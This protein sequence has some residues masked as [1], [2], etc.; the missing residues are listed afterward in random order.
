[1]Y[2]RWN[3]INAPKVRNNWYT[4]RLFIFFNIVII[5]LA[6]LYCSLYRYHSHFHLWYHFFFSFYNY[7][8][9]NYPDS[10]KLSIAFHYRFLEPKG[11]KLWG[12]NYFCRNSM[13]SKREKFHFA[14]SIFEKRTNELIQV[15][16]ITF[17][18]D[19]Y[20]FRQ[21]YILYIP[22]MY[23]KTKAKDIFQFT[24]FL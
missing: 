2:N 21:S 5:K 23:F 8:S 1:M 20:Y 19:Q 9:S 13:K 7:H 3:D 17:W 11:N 24:L 15:H 10:Y 22:C 14:I 16:Y 4:I 18:G 6:F 12:D